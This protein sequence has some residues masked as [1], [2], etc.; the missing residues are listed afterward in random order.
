MKPWILLVLTVVTGSVCFR[1]IRLY[2]DKDPRP[3]FSWVYGA[4]KADE[5]AK[6]AERDVER[7]AIKANNFQLVTF[8]LFL[9]LILANETLQ[10]FSR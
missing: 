2:L 10:A 8:W 4:K 6:R 7:S 5:V 1:S 3:F 9:T